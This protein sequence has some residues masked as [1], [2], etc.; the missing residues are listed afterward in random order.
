[1]AGEKAANG[2]RGIWRDK[3]GP[4]VPG[5]PMPVVALV[6][7]APARGPSVPPKSFGCPIAD[8]RRGYHTSGGRMQ[9]LGKC[10]RDPAQTGGL[11]RSHLTCSAA[12]GRRKRRLADEI[13]PLF[14]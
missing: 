14:A 9:G 7:A 2:G 4:P 3:L 11:K 5:R 1:M 6:I 12:R 10:R 13:R 8:T